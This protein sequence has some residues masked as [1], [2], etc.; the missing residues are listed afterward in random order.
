M[1]TAFSVPVT[2]AAGVTGGVVMVII[3][4]TMAAAAIDGYFH[5]TVT[6]NR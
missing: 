2:F 5:I 6:D 3:F 1:Q 4:N